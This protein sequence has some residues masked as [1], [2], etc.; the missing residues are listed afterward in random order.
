[1]KWDQIEITDN[2][3]KTHKGDQARKFVEL[4]CSAESKIKSSNNGKFAVIL[5]GTRYVKPDVVQRHLEEILTGKV[6]SLKIMSGAKPIVV[7]FPVAKVVPNVVNINPPKLKVE[8]IYKQDSLKKE[9]PKPFKELPIKVTSSLGPSMDTQDNV[10]DF[11]IVAAGKHKLTVAFCD[12]DQ[13]K[14]DFWDL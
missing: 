14:F 3:D 12:P 10:A 13:N 5:K 9:P 8:F 1:M 11:K 7:S 2:D 6:K 4:K